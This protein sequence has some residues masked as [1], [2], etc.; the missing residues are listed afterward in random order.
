MKKNLFTLIELLVVIAIIAILAGMLLPA[1]NQARERGRSSVCK[2]NLKQLSTIMAMYVDDNDGNITPQNKP[3]GK[4]WIWYWKSLGYLTNAKYLNCPSNTDKEIKPSMS[5][6]N[7]DSCYGIGV[8]AGKHKI[9]II[10]NPSAYVIF[11]DAKAY[12]APLTPDDWFD[13][14]NRKVEGAGYDASFPSNFVFRHGGNKK[15]NV[16]TLAGGVSEREKIY[17]SEEKSC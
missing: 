3:S 12:Y 16:V 2:S 17:V 10:T 1:L 15:V 5:T 8:R 14:P 6:S 7:K 13:L 9:S 4:T 11:A